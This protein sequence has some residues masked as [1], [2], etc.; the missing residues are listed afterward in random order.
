VT[1]FDKYIDELQQKIE[2]QELKIYSA[3]VIE[4]AHNP[5]NIRRMEEADCCATV[6][7]WCG[8]TMEIYLRLD[9]SNHI[10]EATFMTDGC[11]PNVACGS[12][13]TL[14][15][16]GLSQEKARNISAHDLIVA[17]NGLPGES[18][19]CAE[20]AVKTLRVALQEEAQP[21]KP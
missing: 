20:L 16:R 15:V 21:N 19:H 11:G 17:L 1:D 3:E 6:T 9:D 8:D 18:V 2:E 13:L 12:M 14:M 5:K 7:G 4:H 10:R